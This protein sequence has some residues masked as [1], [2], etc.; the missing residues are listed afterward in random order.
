MAP[1][2]QFQK[3]SKSFGTKVLFSDLS[4][5]LLAKDRIGLIGPNG[6]GKSTLIKL[7]MEK[8]SPD[9]GH[10][11]RAKHLTIKEIPQ[12]MVFSP[13]QS[14]LACVMAS[15]LQSS[16]EKAEV[17]AKTILAKMGFVDLAR[18]ASSLSGGWQ[19]RLSIACA[20]METPDLLI[21][22][23]PTNHLDLETILWLEHFLVKS[24]LT[25]ILISHDR[26]FLEKTTRTTL[27]VNP[28]FSGHAL[29]TKGPYVMHLK[30]K[31]E[32]L[33]AQ[34]NQGEVLRQK[35][36]R[37]EAWLKTS[38]KARTTKAKYRIDHVSTLRS[39][40]SD[41][42]QHQQ[43]TDLNISFHHSNRKTKKLLSFNRV[44]L[45][46]NSQVILKDM[47]HVMCQGDRLGILGLNGSG[48]SSLL[49]LVTEELKPTS[50]TIK[51]AVDL[52]IAYF[53]QHKQNLE[54]DRTLRYMISDGQEGVVFQGRNYHVN[55]WAGRFGFEPHRLDT[56]VEKLS[57]GEQARLAMSIFMRQEADILILDEPSNDLDIMTLELLEDRLQQF[58][59]A[60]ILVSH[61]RFMLQNLCRSYLGINQEARVVSY[62]DFL[63]WQKTLTVDKKKKAP[64]EAL[65]EK[66]PTKRSKKLS[67]KD[68]REYDQLEKKIATKEDELLKLQQ[69]LDRPEIMADHLEMTK[70]SASVVGLQDEIEAL[71][72]RWQELESKMQG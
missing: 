43:S 57:K 29:M 21:L 17:A 60:L 72:E 58:K 6:A 67:Y 36:K 32:V 16:L 42:R 2:V 50:G 53:D 11:I 44:S 41:V 69:Q 26:A 39:Q 30:Q 31:Q 37:E 70:M 52:K 51:K 49:Q 38:P 14:V 71:Y 25:Y 63:D 13:G 48:K 56:I 27:E 65:S 34:K 18:Q 66:V 68:Q 19:R 33:E 40:L 28:C 10:V 23:E 9:N 3:V 46:R 55:A 7:L 47:D 35:L 61:D 8:E 59:G 22:D 20:L 24:D 12:E 4:F 64:K 1:I 45:V 54:R 15:T 5:S 62:Q